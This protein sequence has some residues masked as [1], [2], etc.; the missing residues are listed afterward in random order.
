MSRKIL[1]LDLDAFFCCV[2][3]LRDPALRG[4]PFAVGGRP[5]QRGVVA[6][7]SYA[8][9][10]FGVRS[11][12][13]MSRAV[14]LCP[15]LLIVPH[16]FK[17]YRAMSAKVMAI[18][19]QYTPLVEQISIDEAFL[20]VTDLVE[21]AEQIARTLQRRINAELQL[22][23]SLGV[24]T[25]KLVAKIAN[26]IGKDAKKKDASGNPPNAIMVV[27]A[28][29][30][31]RFLAPLATNELWGVGPKTAEQL[32][33]LGIQ[34]IGDIAR[35]SEKALTKQFGKNGHDLWLHAQGIDDRRLETDR[36]TKSV[37]RETTFVHDVRDSAILRRTLETLCDDVSRQLHKEKLR[38]T[39]I[40]I[41]L[42]WSDFRTLT[43]QTT[44]ITPT[45]NEAE[46]LKAAM[47]LLDQHRPPQNAVR[48]LGVGVSH[49]VEP[50][51]QLSLWEVPVSTNEPPPTVAHDEMPLLPNVPSAK[52][53]KLRSALDALRSR[54]GEQTVKRASELKNEDG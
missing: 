6:S 26:N 9:R 2:E 18:L 17:A 27:A 16:D 30:E 3:E 48:L 15:D 32:A 14:R 29:D 19:H 51:T 12:M 24:A 44:L 53:E 41:K 42:R 21:S 25:N 31:A 22:S 20:D 45:D 13:P 37:S 35:Y 47:R 4:K 52:Q 1:H 28:G 23:C 43:R 7:C 46:I 11:A 33:A 10:R 49:F 36:E 40:K 38:G 34:T 39:T 50:T 5:E 8:A 54:F